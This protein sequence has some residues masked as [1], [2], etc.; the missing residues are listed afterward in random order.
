[1]NNEYRAELRILKKSKAKIMRDSLKTRLALN[2]QEA[3][4]IKLCN[5]TRKTIQRESDRVNL[6]VRREMVKVEQ[7]IAI[8][9]GRLS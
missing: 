6:R 3:A 2:K 8:L 9:E 4:A 7:R 5:S 1:M